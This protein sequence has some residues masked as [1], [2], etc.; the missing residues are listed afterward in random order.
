MIIK[1]SDLR[2][3]EIYDIINKSNS[4]YE[5]KEVLKE[6]I[7]IKSDGL[8]HIT[9]G[10]R[11]AIN[12]L[13]NH[14]IRES[15]DNSVKISW[16]SYCEDMHEIKKI[17]FR[18]KK[19]Y[20]R[21]IRELVSGF[22]KYIIINVAV[23]T[24]EIKELKKYKNLLYIEK[25]MKTAKGASMCSSFVNDQL[26][27]NFPLKSRMEEL[28]LYSYESHA[29]K[30]IFYTKTVIYLK[31]TN[32]F[33][34]TLLTE[35]IESFPKEKGRG[36]KPTFIEYRQFLYY[37]ANSLLTV[38]GSR[39]LLPE[40]II[41]FTFT[42]FNNQYRFYKKLENKF[43]VLSDRTDKS[44]EGR[45]SHSLLDIL[46]EFYLFLIYKIQDE[47]IEHNP[48]LGT[49]INS[50][51]L[52]IF[53]FRN[54]YEKGYCFVRRTGF[55]DIPRR[56]RWAIVS[57]DNKASSS[58]NRV[59]G[60][61]FTEITD[62]I[63]RED[64]KIFIWSEF[65]VETKHLVSEYAFIRS[66]LI[67]KYQY[68]VECKNVVRLDKP[69]AFTEEF[70]L[71][72]RAYMISKYNNNE[73]SLGKAFSAVK[74]FL[75]ANYSKYDLSEGV[76]TYLV[77]KFRGKREYGGN[78]ISK[79][80]FKL[81]KEGIRELKNNTLG[82]ELYFIILAL[83]ATTKLRIGEILN[84]E[85]DCIISIDKDEGTGEI[86][87]H[88]KTSKKVVN[89]KLSLDKINLIEKA[90]EITLE[91]SQN[92][93]TEVRRYI[94]ISKLEIFENINT[95]K[96]NVIQILGEK[97]NYIF[98]GILRDKNIGDRNYKVNNLRH[99]FKD[100]VWEQGIKDGISTMR[101]EYM[102]GTTF[103]TD[104]MNYRAMSNAQTFAEMF[105]GVRISDVSINGDIVINEEELQNL[106]PVESGRGGCK[107]DDC[108]NENT[109]NKML[110]CLICD[111]FVTCV[112][113]K[114]SFKK[115][116]SE[117][118]KELDETISNEKR[119]YYESELKLNAAFYSK[120]IEINEG[121][122]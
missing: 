84:L 52:L 5:L 86:K 66:F 13:E 4:D 64:L 98:R 70:M 95:E 85:R 71:Y 65:N 53:V 48:F 44:R 32:L 108:K 116:I 2:R 83:N 49:A 8:L 42:I 39:C 62:R 24:N 6:F 26:A 12:I 111:S 1:S 25:R 102:T 91:L 99:T 115:R 20:G 30:V 77:L 28:Y 81:I 78:P 31:D 96:V 16:E 122:E 3:Q 114:D 35:F 74:K 27:T 56:N 60:I 21:E 88:C 80:D 106:R 47:G 97:V 112:S 36:V 93:M 92:A 29:S 15:T 41:D 22:Y 118:K 46:K 55:E 19:Q 121:K 107:L 67:L 50:E 51:V 75:R 40:S 110:K 120:I 105:S 79:D 63:L 23:P 103:K 59:N 104:V 9:K 34:M 73:S 109:I 7:N 38:V 43:C 10:L 57:E 117:L 45:K 37:F 69:S 89:T 72:F 33:L 100:T 61:D 11:L 101:I 14:F 18:N 54:Y 119:N 82:G 76:F 87:Y 58:R 113:R 90:A 17:D 68:D 94:F